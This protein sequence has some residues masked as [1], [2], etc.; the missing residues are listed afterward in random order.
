[1]PWLISHGIR[2]ILIIVIA[3]VLDRVLQRIVVRTVRA[4]VRPDANTSPEAE[5]KR[6]DTLIRIFSGALK[7]LIMIVAFMMIL[8][9]TGIEIPFPQT[10][11]H[12]TTE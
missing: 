6:E 9:E 11:I 2:I 3:F 12:P 1:V 10:V 7:I 8:Q 5:K 4:S